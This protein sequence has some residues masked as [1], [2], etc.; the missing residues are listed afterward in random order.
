M[1]KT[2]GTILPHPAETCDFFFFLIFQS[3]S[4]AGDVIQQIKIRKPKEHTLQ[5]QPSL[6]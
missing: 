5:Q 1:K 2:Y 4:A 6:I 3:Q